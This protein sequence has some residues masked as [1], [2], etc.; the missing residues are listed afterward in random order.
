MNEFKDAAIAEG[1][2]V[3]GADRSRRGRVRGSWR[4]RVRDRSGLWR[5]PPG[6]NKWPVACGGMS[7]G[8]KN[9][10]FVAGEVASSP[11]A[12]GMLMMGCNQDLASAGCARVAAAV[13]FRA[14]FEQ[15]NG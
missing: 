8:A 15:R 3:M 11:P 6:A 13:S 14:I 5:S 7:G 10:A 2:I 4:S 12:I 9:S 1:W